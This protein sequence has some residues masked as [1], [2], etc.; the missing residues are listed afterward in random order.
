LAGQNDFF[1]F[2]KNLKRF[3]L[4]RNFKKVQKPQKTLKLLK[5]FLSVKTFEKFHILYFINTKTCQPEIS[6][7]LFFSINLIFN[8]KV[9]RMLVKGPCLFL[10]TLKSDDC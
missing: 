9:L 5:N 10:L 6:K 3:D 4:L 8:G 1:L 7:A 2:Y